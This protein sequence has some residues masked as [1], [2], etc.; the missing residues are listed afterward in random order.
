MFRL[1]AVF[2]LFAVSLCAR[3][4]SEFEKIFESRSKCAVVVQ[5][6]VELEEDRNKRQCVGMVAGED[7]LVIVTSAEI[8]G[9]LR[10]ESL[11]DFK[12]RIFGGDSEGYPADYLGAD[13]I[14]GTHFIKIRGGLKDG[15]LPFSSFPKADCSMG[16]ALWG[17]LLDSESADFEPMMCPSTLIRRGKYPLDIGYF[18]S[19]IA[20]NSAPIFDKSG[21]FDG[22]ATAYDENDYLLYAGDK[23]GEVRLLDPHRASVMFMPSVVDELLARIPKNPAGDPFG[24]V[25]LIDLQILKSDVA[26]YLGLEKKSAFVVSEIVKDSPAEKSGIKKG[27]IITG[28]NGKPIERLRNDSATLSNFWLSLAKSKP[29]DRIKL[30]IIS[31]NS[32]PRELEVVLDQSP[33]TFRQS[34]FKYFKRLGFSVREFL[35]DD[36]IARKTF[37]RGDDMAVVQ[38]VKPNSPAS[39]AVP[40]ALRQEDLIKEINSIPVKS[41][42]HAVE[43]LEKLE[44]DKSAKEVVI[45]AEDFSETKVIRVKLD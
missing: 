8:P 28:Y 26:K 10:L 38:F 34:K 22:W 6:V 13:S 3:A 11:K 7:G 32:A 43:L 30:E 23:S 35:L 16:D 42:A 19:V 39:S 15:M 24:W 1:I 14:T 31:G 45:L 27:D 5:Y 40:A 41:Y 37:R 21:N 20:S 44:S 4:D 18:S 33:K 29:G 2:C 12:I 36:S 25:G 9:M 17:V